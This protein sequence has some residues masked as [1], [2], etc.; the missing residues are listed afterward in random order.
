VVFQFSHVLK[1]HF[2]QCFQVVYEIIRSKN[3]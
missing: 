3:G 2:A 1:V